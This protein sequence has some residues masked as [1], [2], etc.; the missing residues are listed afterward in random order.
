MSNEIGAVTA[1]PHLSSDC[2]QK[3]SFGAPGVYKQNEKGALFFKPKVL[4]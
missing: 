4:K 3:E 2:W 1:A